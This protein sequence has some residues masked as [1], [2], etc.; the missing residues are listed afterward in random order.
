[1]HN[2]AD[3]AR[4]ILHM[5]N[6]PVAPD[7]NQ[8]LEDHM[9]LEEKENTARLVEIGAESPSA[10]VQKALDHSF[11]IQRMLQRDESMTAELK[12]ELLDHFIEEHEIWSLE[13]SSSQPTQSSSSQTITRNWTVGPLWPK[14]G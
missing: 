7:V 1:V 6:Q 3:H 11:F 8:R 14:G 5:L 2:I 9:L 4:T 12:K 13:L 10:I